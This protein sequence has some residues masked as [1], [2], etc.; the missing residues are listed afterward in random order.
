VDIRPDC[1]RSFLPERGVESVVKCL[2]ARDG[3]LRA[4]AGGRRTMALCRG[5]RA[6]LIW[7]SVRRT[8]PRFFRGMPGGLPPW[9]LAYGNG[10]R[11]NDAK[12]ALP[13][14]VEGGPGG[15]GMMVGRRGELTH[16]TGKSDLGERNLVPGAALSATTETRDWDQMVRASAARG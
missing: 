8:G 6:R 11:S 9:R 10:R 15:A 1:R 16:S 5:G 12:T 3:R 2:S 4:N 14:W 7:T 13:Q